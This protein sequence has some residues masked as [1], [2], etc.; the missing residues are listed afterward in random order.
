MSIFQPAINQGEWHGMGSASSLSSSSSSIIQAQHSN[1]L[2][3]IA[4]TTL[5]AAIPPTAN[6]TSLTPL[7]SSPSSTFSTSSTLPI[8]IPHQQSSGQNKVPT[9]EQSGQVNINMGLKSELFILLG[10][11][12]W[13]RT[14]E[15]AQIHVP[16]SMDDHKFF[17]ALLREYKRRRGLWRLWFSVWQ[18]RYCDFVK[19]EKFRPGRIIVSKKHDIPEDLLYEYS[20]R[21]PHADVPPIQPEEFEIALS[22]CN[23]SCFFWLFHDCVGTPQGSDALERIPK[24]RGEFEL[25]SGAREYA[26]GLEAHHTISFLR[27]LIYHLIIFAGPF[28]FWGWWQSDHPWDLQDASIPLAA[29]CALLSLFWGSSGTLRFIRERG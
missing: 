14:L 28:A 6:I 11:K 3:T 13:R 10:I 29:V 17:K 1:Q 21:P 15:L 18:L 5:P 20:P 19:F 26:W 22:S 16:N 2:R 8:I 23:S 25:K 27:M 9:E 12:G 7:S 24:R 4:A